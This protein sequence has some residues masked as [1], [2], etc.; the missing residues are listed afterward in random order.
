[1]GKEQV[2]CSQ[3]LLYVYIDN[4]YYSEVKNLSAYMYVL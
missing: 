2:S 4:N 1:M 3:F